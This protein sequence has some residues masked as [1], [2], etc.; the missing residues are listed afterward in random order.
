[1]SWSDHNLAYLSARL[2]EIRYE[3]ELE[4]AKLLGQDT[5]PL[6]PPPSPKWTGRDTH[7]SALT[8]LSQRAGLEPFEQK[9]LLI[10]VGMELDA[11]FPAL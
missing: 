4:Q 9:L 5:D 3:L 2:E 7:Q 11:R 10:C 6:T 8:S 1:M